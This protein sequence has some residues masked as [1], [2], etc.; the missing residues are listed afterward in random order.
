MFENEEQPAKLAVMQVH[1]DKFFYNSNSRLGAHGGLMDER[2]FLLEEQ[3]SCRARALKFSGETNRR[4]KALEERR[5]Q[6]AVQEQR[7]RENILQQRRQRVQEATERFQR[8][9]LPPPQ[10]QRPSFR[11]IV[12]NIEDALSQIQ[13]TLKTFTRQSSL[14]SSNSNINRGCPPAPKPPTVSKSSHCRAAEEAYAKVLTEQ[15]TVWFRNSQQPQKT[16]EKEDDAFSVQE[17]AASPLCNSESLS[18]PDSLE[19][20]EPTRRNVNLQ[21]SYSSLLLDLKKP[22]LVQ[23]SQ[24]DS[25]PS[26]KQNCF[27]VMMLVD[28]KSAQQRQTCEPTHKKQEELNNRMHDPYKASCYFTS[29]AQTPKTEARPALNNGSLLTKIADAD[30]K[31]CDEDSARSSP[32]DN[33]IVVAINEPA[34]ADAALGSCQEPRL[35]PSQRVHDDIQLKHLSATELLLPAKNGNGEDIIFG[36]RPKPNIFPTHNTTDNASRGEAIQQTR[37]ENHYLSSQKE[38]SVSLNNLNK[39]LNSEPK[40]EKPVSTVTLQHACLSNI[41]SVTPKCLKEEVQTLPLSVG[42]S[43]SDS[44]ICQVRFIKGIL[45]KQSA[46]DTSPYGSGHIIF[47]KQVVAIAIRDSIELTRAKSKE[48]E[49][50]TIKKKLR[51]FDEV[52]LE[53]E[54]KDQNVNIGRQ[55]KAKDSNL[56]QSKNNSVDHQLSITAVSGAYKLGPGV[57]PPASTSYHFTK[58]AWADVGVQ[59]SMPQERGDEVKVPQSSTRTGGPK[60]PRRARSARPTV[61]P[62]SSPARKGTVIRPQSATEVTQIANTQGKMMMPR[63]PPRTETVEEKTGGRTAYNT[64]TPLNMD[65]AGV[66]CK[67]APDVQQ[68]PHKDNPGSLFSP[69]A[70]HVIRTDSNV[71]YTPVPPTYTCSVLEGNAK[72]PPRPGHQEPQDCRGRR[73][74]VYTEKELCLDCTPTD[75][76]ISQLWQGVRNALATK[77]ERALIRRQESSRAGRRNY[78]GEQSRQAPGSGN[79]RFPLPSQPLKQAG[80]LVRLYPSTCD[81]AFTHEVLDSAAHFHLADGRAGGPLEDKRLTAAMETAKTQN[82]RAVHQ[83][84]SQQHGLTA[85][86]M[87]EQRILLSLDRLNHQLHCVQE[88]GAANSGFALIDAPCEVKSTTIHHKLRAFPADSRSGNQRKL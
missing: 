51:W 83:Q 34:P 65:H 56:S 77:D 7:L 55:M 62:V 44:K 87:E 48:A 10:R 74:L 35:A 64:R 25:S 45:K 47:A 9:H 27:S 61:V 42:M 80:D 33:V 86:S 16:Q 39:I 4:R 28:D 40:I 31:C 32:N 5:K 70:H 53:N 17:D 57:T 72:S 29:I 13:G 20:E 1:Q 12:P 21:S 14:L 68:D 52:H 79:R 76:E 66:N 73:G 78:R 81:K 15:S 43:H 82:S 22:V 41:Q 88:H 50:K 67:Q 19:E 38:F 54:D 18:S 36:A 63:P 58:Q 30:P 59:V 2:Q 26:S 11:N 3:K 71:M 75:E 37:K 69:Q 6:W 49:D 46:D 85:I 60:V 84:H 23:R 24:N 8:G